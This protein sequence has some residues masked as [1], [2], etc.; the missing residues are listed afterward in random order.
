MASSAAKSALKIQRITEAKC[1]E[2]AANPTINPLTGKSIELDGPTYNTLKERCLTKYNIALPAAAEGVFSRGNSPDPAAA[3]ASS[4]PESASSKSVETKNKTAGWKKPIPKTQA[5]ALAIINLIGQQIW[6][7]IK[8]LVTAQNN[9]PVNGLKNFNVA[10]IFKN[11]PYYRPYIDSI[12]NEEMFDS[13]YATIRLM[14]IEDP[15]MRKALHKS[16]AGTYTQARLVR[17]VDPTAPKVIVILH[18]VFTFLLSLHGT[19]GDIVEITA[20]LNAIQPHLAEAQRYVDNLNMALLL[21]R[22]RNATNTLGADELTANIARLM[23]TQRPVAAAAAPPAQQGGRR[24]N[25]K[26][27]T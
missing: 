18:K 17:L 3:A 21:R 2:W 26:K 22:A 25:T 20:V 9:D 4:S 7:G 8:A 23:L 6:T 1:R 14:R 12:N 11:L 16:Q 19:Y 13:P 5:A 27:N 10:T 15:L 24:R